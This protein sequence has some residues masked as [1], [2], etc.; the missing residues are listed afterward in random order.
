MRELMAVRGDA[1]AEASLGDC[2][3]IAAVIGRAAGLEG[4]VM[5]A[6]GDFDGRVRMFD[7]GG[8]RVCHVVCDGPMRVD[9][10]EVAESDWLQG[11]PLHV[12]VQLSGTL[13]IRMGGR[14][15][16]SLRPE[17]W[18]AV[19]HVSKFWADASMPVEFMV[20]VARGEELRCVADGLTR[21][22]GHQASA[23]SGA[24]RVF[25]QI[26]AEVISQAPDLDA[27][28]RLSLSNALIQ[29]LKASIFDL[30]GAPAAQAPAQLYGRVC[31]LIEANLG[32]EDLSID[33]LA[34]R[35]RCSKR[36]LH[37]LF[38]RHQAKRTL[39]DY[40]NHRR[41]E[42]CRTEL[43]MGRG[44]SIAEVAHR[45]GFHDPSYFAR[46]FRREYAIS[47]SALL[48]AAKP[49]AST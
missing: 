15:A 39:N 37:A 30:T 44:R 6:S 49:A 20:L 17:E 3:P 16:I 25:R 46:L 13:V 42:Q 33:Y 43:T 4:A 1:Y 7:L 26:L 31:E 38:A 47:P 18:C 22:S 9:G 8:L 24:A 32:Q 28:S 35:M 19:T 45:W 23:G 27:A 2:R 11:G 12:L 40:I 34:E 36:Y 14:P 48:A 29:S 21:L 10:R 5:A 41:L